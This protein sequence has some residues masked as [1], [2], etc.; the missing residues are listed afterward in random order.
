MIKN[1]LFLIFLSYF[2]LNAAE[3]SIQ[4]VGQSSNSLQLKISFPE[5]QLI[6]IPDPSKKHIVSHIYMD[7][8]SMLEEEGFPR[9]P[10]LTRMF[11]L[12][13]KQVSSRILDI[14]KETIPV[15]RYLINLPTN[16]NSQQVAAKGVKNKNR[17]E[18]TDH[19]LFRDVPVFTLNI[20][21]VSLD[22]TGE[23][24]EVIRSL[25][26]EITSAS[27]KT[28]TQISAASYSPKD[29]SVLT[30]LLINGDQVSYKLDR[31]LLKSVI[32]NQS[33]QSGRYKLLLNQ[34]GLYKITY[35]DLVAAE[36]PAEQ[37]DTRKLRLV[38][39][40]QE[41]PVYFKGGEDGIFDP[42]DYFEFWGVKNEKTF[43]DK[44]VDV[45]SDPFSD[46]NVYWLE[47]GA[48]SGRRMA[49]ESGALTVSNPSQFIVP[50]SYTEN[51]HFEENSAFHRFGNV[52][53]DSLN[54]SMDHWYYDRGITAVGSRTNEAIIPWPY[55]KLSTRSVYIKAMMR[56][57]SVK[58]SANPL[59]DHRVEIWLNDRLAANSGTWKN[60]NLHL[61]TN[62][63]SLR[64]DRQSGSM[65][66]QH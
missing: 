31:P 41:I 21:P 60:Q 17:I 20:F 27:S 3:S 48:S 59:Y 23:K 1:V 62:E 45:Y 11:S 24:V 32:T 56:G 42:G 54:Y 66:R 39:R 47:E 55:T 40:G 37:M 51:L 15:T 36:V 38:N 2:F 33:Y 18:I 10:Y 19:G 53:I 46:V 12:P 9:I 44:Y 34:T 65:I 6:E 29:R 57:L 7:G 28:K 14:Q 30:K 5:P 26:L 25:T 61:L 35:D 64:I 13:S 8:L 43:L 4:I 50:F 22:P 63:G 49:E 58:S 52:N 16:L